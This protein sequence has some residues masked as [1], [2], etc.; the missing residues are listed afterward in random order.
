[1]AAQNF[2]EFALKLNPRDVQDE[3]L[4]SFKKLA[5]DEQVLHYLCRYLTSLGFCSD[6]S[7]DN[8]HLFDTNLPSRVENE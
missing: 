3:L 5:I 8:L 4:A 7:S 2:G 1:M 6:S